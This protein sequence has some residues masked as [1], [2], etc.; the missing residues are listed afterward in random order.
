[1]P[2]TFTTESTSEIEVLFDTAEGFASDALKTNGE[3]PAILFCQTGG[4]DNFAVAY[5][6]APTAIQRRVMALSLGKM[7]RNK[8]VVRFAV[9]REV[10]Y[11]VFGR[12]EDIIPP[13]QC[14]DRIDSVCIEIH[15]IE[16]RMWWRGFR[17][18]TSGGK[19]T[20]EPFGED[21]GDA[22]NLQTGTFDG[23]LSDPDD[24]RTIN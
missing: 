17:K 16:D 15:D 9:V 24:K 11:K 2:D 1:M 12:D 6:T 10:W 18:D 13:S 8:G 4:S 7:L 22:N 19:M 5:E 14:P 20:L 23:L 21:F 3:V